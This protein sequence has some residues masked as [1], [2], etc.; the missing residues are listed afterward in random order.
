MHVGCA[1]IHEHA[2]LMKA[3]AW[4]LRLNRIMSIPLAFEVV[5][6][7]VVGTLVVDFVA[8]EVVVAAFVVLDVVVVAFVVVHVVLE[9]GVLFVAFVVVEEV[10]ES[11]R[12]RR[13]EEWRGGWWK[14]LHGFRLQSG[15]VEA[16]N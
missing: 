4:D 14:E 1:S 2:V 9:L 16:T 12:R 15:L 10:A 5:V 8:L 13:R 7:N 3:D 11:R 6:D